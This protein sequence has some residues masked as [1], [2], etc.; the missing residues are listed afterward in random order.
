MADRPEP[1]PAQEMLDLQ[2]ILMCH[3]DRLEVEHLL[4]G[5]GFRPV[6]H[7]SQLDGLR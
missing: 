7:V 1:E 5:L 6:S 4:G 3:Q 2:P